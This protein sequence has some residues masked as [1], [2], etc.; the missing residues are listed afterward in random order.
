MMAKRFVA[1][2]HNNIFHLSFSNSHLLLFAGA[3]RTMT[4]QEYA[5]ENDKCLVSV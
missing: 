1:S 4:N 5:M 3:A 2:W